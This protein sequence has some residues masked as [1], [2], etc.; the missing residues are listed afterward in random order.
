M[1]VKRAG[2]WP[3]SVMR[4]VMPAGV[5]STSPLFRVRTNDPFALDPVG[6]LVVGDRD[7]HVGR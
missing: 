3:V 2:A 4:C 7:Q 5:Y 6:Q 1:T